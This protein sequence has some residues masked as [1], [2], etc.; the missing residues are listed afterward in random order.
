MWQS[1]A[2][3]T[4]AGA[5]F[6]YWYW[7]LVTGHPDQI[8]NRYE[9]GVG[10][11]YLYGELEHIVSVLTKESPFVERPSVLRRTGEIAKS[12]YDV[13]NFDFLHF[14]DPGPILRQARTE[15]EKAVQRR[16]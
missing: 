7:L 4:R 13:P 3:A 16:L 1:L 14:D 15:L 2:C 8:D 12:C 5:D 11:H 6:P 10:T 9:T